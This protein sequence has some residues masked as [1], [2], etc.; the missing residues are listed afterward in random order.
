MDIGLNSKDFPISLFSLKSNATNT[1]AL[2]PAC[3]CKKKC[4]NCGST[5]LEPAD[6]DSYYSDPLKFYMKHRSSLNAK[7]KIAVS[8]SI[9]FGFEHESFRSLSLSKF[10]YNSLVATYALAFVLSVG[11]AIV[12]IQS[13][14]LCHLSPAKK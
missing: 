14:K 3:S 1:T 12:A 6:D 10:T 8:K 11:L 5:A 13:K 9:N 7:M 4:S 2:R